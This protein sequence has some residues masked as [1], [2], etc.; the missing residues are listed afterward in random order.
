MKAIKA[1][2]KNFKSLDILNIFKHFKLIILTTIILVIFI[3]APEKL[4]AN[5][6]ELSCKNSKNTATVVYSY[7]RNNVILTSSNNNKIKIKFLMSSKTA[8]SFKSDGVIGNLKT[9]LTY[10]PNINELSMRQSSLRGKNI[11]LKCNEAKLLKEE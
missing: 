9:S 3:L 8:N 4:I 5:I 1:I 6:Y 11:F 10:N 2:K 7:K